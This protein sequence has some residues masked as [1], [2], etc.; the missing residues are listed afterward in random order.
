MRR[1]TLFRRFIGRNGARW[2]QWQEQ[3]REGA[4]ACN[5]KKKKRRRVRAQER[6]DSVR[7]EGSVMAVSWT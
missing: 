7:A 1:G 4:E 6:R 5:R 2:K 3:K